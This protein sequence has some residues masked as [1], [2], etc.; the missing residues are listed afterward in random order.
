MPLQVQEG[1]MFELEEAAFSLHS[2]ADK[3]SSHK[4]SDAGSFT[5]GPTGLPPTSW[6]LERI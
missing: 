1:G 2:A 3:T 6:E 5:V 4:V